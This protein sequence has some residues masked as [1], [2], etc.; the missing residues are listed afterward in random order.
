MCVLIMKICLLYVFLCIIIYKR[1]LC[2]LKCLT[3]DDHNFQCFNHLHY[4]IGNITVFKGRVTL[5][6]GMSV[7]N[8]ILH[9]TN[10]WKS[11]CYF[12]NIRNN[13]RQL[14]IFLQKLLLAHSFHTGMLR[15]FSCI[16]GWHLITHTICDVLSWEN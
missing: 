2:Y 16:S 6:V 15:S 12:R 9:V 7:D 13:I 5:K 10:Y 11:F 3:E 8:Y 1:C 14:Y 4:F